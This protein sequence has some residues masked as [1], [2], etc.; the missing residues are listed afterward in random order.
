[1]RRPVLYIVVPCYNEEEVL[2]ET[3][4]R[5]IQVI[6]Q[7]IAQDM[8][9][10][11]SR[12]LCVDDGS[13]DHT[14][15]LICRLHATTPYVCGVK[16]AANSGHQNALLAGLLTA[17][18][19]CDIMV[20]I[21]A[22]LQDDVEVMPE[23]VRKYLEGN[24]IVYGV[25]QSRASDTWFKRTTA[26][27]FYKL[28]RVLGVKS[29]YNH[30]DYRLMSRRAVEQLSEYR[31]RNLF[32]RGLVP[33]IGYKSANV[34]FNRE[35]RFAGESKYPFK[36]MLNFAVDGVTSF[37]IQPLRLLI[38]VGLLFILISIAI[39]IW[40][41]VRYFGNQ[42]VPGWSSIILSIW[43]VGGTI[44]MG[45]GIMGEYI[46]KMYIEV[47]DRPRYNIETVLIDDS[48]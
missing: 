22:D 15:E 34:Y 41:M 7:M 48:E 16:L 36:K 19:H 45:M 42:V 14:W 24:D 37:S 3:S 6:E 20:S 44:L 26:L 1:M 25:R 32:L 23:M 5:I 47:K 11:A 4:R 35:K 38:H 30:A 8:I 27:G 31:E 17:C 33:L 29:V 21:D 12:I 13:H 39:F 28:M 10:A 18:P 46:G 40:V 2:E 9:D 43:F